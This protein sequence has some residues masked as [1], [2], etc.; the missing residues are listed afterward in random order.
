MLK[1]LNAGE[2]IYAIIDGAHRLQAMLIRALDPSVEC[3]TL[4]TCIPVVPHDS[5]V[6]FPRAHIT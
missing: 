1:V 3:V 2:A 4:D 6:P 5:K